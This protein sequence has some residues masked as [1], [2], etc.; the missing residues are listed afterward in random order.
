M[1]TIPPGPSSL[2]VEPHK[3]RQVA[4]SFGSDPERY[5]RTRP[6]YPQA[7]VDRVIATSPGTEVLDVGI[8]T[9]VSAEAFQARGCGVLGVEPDERMAEVARRHGFEVEVANFEQ[10][11]AAG[12][13]FDAVISGQAW[14][15][16]DP[17]SGAAKA[18]EVLRPHGCLAVFWNVFQPPPDLADAFA[19]VYRQVLPGSPF[20]RAAV[21]GMDVYSGLFAR[22]VDG[23]RASAVFAEPQRW[24]FDWER[25]YTKHEWLE[26]VPTFGGHSKLPPGKLDDLLVGTGAAIDAVGGQF[27]MA[28]TAVLLTAEVLS[29]D[30]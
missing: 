27:T 3:A 13:T 15:W 8:G 5:D 28:Y 4:E 6:R 17:V 26:Q 16:V 21:P 29:D 20:F 2:S 22:V 10:W 18:A 12:R 25:A 1:V 30:D 23:L 14:H 19:A 7:L 24:A 11:D 9:G